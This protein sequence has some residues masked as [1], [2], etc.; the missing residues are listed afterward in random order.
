MAVQVQN[1][2]GIEPPVQVFVRKGVLDDERYLSF[3]FPDWLSQGEVLDNGWAIDGNAVLLLVSKNDLLT[4]ERKLVEWFQ[5]KGH[6]IT[7]V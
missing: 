1:L 6:G 5:K 3:K 2:E 7:F 4:A